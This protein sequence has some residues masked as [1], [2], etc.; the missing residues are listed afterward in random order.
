MVTYDRVHGH[1]NDVSGR[2][3]TSDSQRASIVNQREISLKTMTNTWEIKD[4][5]FLIKFQNLEIETEWEEM[6][7][8][9]K[10]G[11]GKELPLMREL[12]EYNASVFQL[13][14]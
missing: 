4:Q 13:P 3:K 10:M 2:K 7:D 14:T 9:Y 12:L 6:E 8:L 11:E 5:N 1:D